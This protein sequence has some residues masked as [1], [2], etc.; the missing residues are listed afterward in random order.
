MIMSDPAS[1]TGAFASGITSTVLVLVHPFDPVTVKVNVPVAST[2]GIALVPFVIVPDPVQLY[3]IPVPVEAEPS[4]LTVVTP[5]GKLTLVP[6]S[7]IG[8]VISIVKVAVA[9]AVHPLSVFVTVIV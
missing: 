9:S 1:A 2:V 4:R 5:H 7:A 3:V 6:A 8:L